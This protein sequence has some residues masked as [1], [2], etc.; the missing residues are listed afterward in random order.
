MFK[1]TL[2]SS[3]LVW[4]TLL[5]DNAAEEISALSTKLSSGNPT[6]GVRIG[7]RF[8]D[9]WIKCL[10][11]ESDYCTYSPT[12]SQLWYNFHI[13][14]ADSSVC[15]S[16]GTTMSIQLFVSSTFYQVYQTK[17]LLYRYLHTRTLNHNINTWWIKY[18]YLH[19]YIYQTQ[20]IPSFT[21]QL[22]IIFT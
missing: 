3:N 7:T 22:I 13:E 12:Y 14:T 4:T 21:I 18:M 9:T 11:N 10:R 5:L 19:N 1:W 15:N 16:D 8:Q 6:F 17:Y 2:A 20:T